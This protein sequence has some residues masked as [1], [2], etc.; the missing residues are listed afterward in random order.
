MNKHEWYTEQD[1]DDPWI[2]Q[3]MDEEKERQLIEEQQKIAC[4]VMKELLKLR[5]WN[6]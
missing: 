4:H 5:S 6:K 3:E 1:Q 2:Q